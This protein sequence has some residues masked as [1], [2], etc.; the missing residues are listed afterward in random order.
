MGNSESLH[1]K[2]NSSQKNLILN[3][4]LKPQ[5]IFIEALREN[6]NTF[7]ISWK[8]FT[9]KRLFKSA[10]MFE[11][12]DEL[13]TFKSLNNNFLKGIKEF[14]VLLQKYWTST[15]NLLFP[16]KQKEIL[17]YSELLRKK[18]AKKNA[19]RIF[20]VQDTIREFRKLCKDE[21]ILG[22]VSEINNEIKKNQIQN[23]NFFLN[24]VSTFDFIGR[25]ILLGTA[26]GDVIH[27]NKKIRYITTFE[28]KIKI[29]RSC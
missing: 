10:E 25:D 20:H 27:Y 13:E 17:V 19:K 7:G 2:I 4:I 21:S 3:L 24:T 26:T 8:E 29:K 28:G 15:L 11:F 23:C 14:E 12:F 1:Q 6:L 9:T 22:K 18:I 5:S 16:K